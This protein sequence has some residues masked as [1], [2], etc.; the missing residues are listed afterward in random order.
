[1]ASA[2]FGESGIFM[3]YGSLRGEA[4]VVPPT[5]PRD[6]A[7]GGW[8]QLHSCG[9]SGTTTFKKVATGR[10]LQGVAQGT[11]I[12]IT[13]QTDASS[14]QLLRDAMLGRQYNDVC[15]VFLHTGH[16]GTLEQYL[17]LEIEKANIVSFNMLS[18]DERATESYEIR[19]MN[20]RVVTI[21][22]GSGPQSVANVVNTD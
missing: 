19:Y 7:S 20:M 8:M 12:R 6:P 21:A 14:I 2:S 10:A 15:I 5:I 17:R 3:C 13:K 18:A 11:P 22:A 1:M 4:S 16:G 9:F